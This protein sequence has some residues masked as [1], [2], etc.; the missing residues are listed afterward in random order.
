MEATAVLVVT[1][2]A[3]DAVVLAAL[4]LDHC[5]NWVPVAY[6]AISS[7]RWVGQRLSSRPPAEQNMYK[8]KKNILDCIL[9]SMMTLLPIMPIPYNDQ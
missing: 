5:A 3:V 8:A 1:H 4:E 2:A 7:V 9:L 6:Q